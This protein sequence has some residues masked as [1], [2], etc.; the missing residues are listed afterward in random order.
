MRPTVIP[1]ALDGQP[2]RT[3]NAFALGVS[4]KTL[5]G[6]R[7]RRIAKGVYVAAAAADSHRIRVRGVMLT[8]PPG[9]VATGVTGLQLLGVD[10]G[11]AAPMV[12]ASIH[13]WPVRRRDVKVISAPQGSLPV[14]PR[15]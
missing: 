13:P 7:F 8:L 11:S 10:V 2:F 12:F 14:E 6:A 4:L 1:Q 3:A 9:T 15:H 5:R